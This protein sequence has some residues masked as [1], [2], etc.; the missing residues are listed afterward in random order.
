MKTSAKRTKTTAQPTSRSKQTLSDAQ[1]LQLLLEMMAIP[2]RSGEE[3]AIMEF[4]QHKLVAA[5]ATAKSLVFDGAHRR[6][7][8]GGQVG[9]LILKLPG[10]Q[11]APQRMLSA[12]VDTVPIC[13][14]SR[15]VRKGKLIVSANKNAGLGG[16][17]RAGAAVILG[18]A[19]DILRNKLPHPPLTFLWTVQEEIGLHGARCVQ[20]SKLGRPA[21]AFNFDGGSP[22][23]LKI[24]ATGGYRMTIDIEGLASHAGGHPEQGISA[25]A[26]ASVAI[27]DLVRNGWH[28]L[29]QKGDHTGTSNVGVIH[30]G[31]ATNV[32]TDHVRVCVEA[33]SHDPKFRRQIVAEIEAA[34]KRATE[35]IQNANGKRGRVKFDGHLDYESFC[36]PLEE[37]A[38]TTATAA[39]EAENLVSELGVTNGGLDANWLTAHGI[40]TVTLGCGQRN[41]HTAAEELVIAEYHQARRI[42]LRLATGAES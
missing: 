30:G 21:S 42:A 2:G 13:V 25:I 20:V 7:P 15:P 5:G 14:G 33:R 22:A 39:I 28:G 11:R 23:I 18:A 38:V 34:F 4:I 16:D 10:T 35:A 26:I 40:P 3:G 41:I 36:L 6:S 37:P 19:L 24:G 1:A 32:V 8:F 29:I 17:D 9:N 12:H 31:E 27:A